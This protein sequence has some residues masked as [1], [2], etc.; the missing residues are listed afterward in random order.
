MIG[1]PGHSQIAVSFSIIVPRIG[2]LGNPEALPQVFDGRPSMPKP[3]RAEKYV[4]LAVIETHSGP[5][6]RAGSGGGRQCLGRSNRDGALLLL[7]SAQLQRR[8]W[9]LCPPDC[10]PRRQSLWHDG[11]WRCR[12]RKR[13]VFKVTGT[14]FGVIPFSAFSGQI[15]FG[16]SPNTDSFELNASDLNASFT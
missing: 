9:S 4:A 15:A 1:S 7:Q 8:G 13:L 14:G 10:R 12:S 3:C 5:L 11:E 16:L 6:R 2:F